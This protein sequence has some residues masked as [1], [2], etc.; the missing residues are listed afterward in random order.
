MNLIL[1]GVKLGLI[2]AI[3]VG[4]IF[5]AL[6]QAGVEEGAR[7]GSMVGFGIWASDILF[8]LCSYFGVSWI[9]KVVEGPR[10]TLY[11]GIGGSITLA[12]FGLATLLT[13]PRA[14][15]NPHWAKT[16]IRSTSYFSLWLKGFLINTI[17]PF[18]FFFWIGVTTTMVMDGGLDSGEASLFFGGILGTIITTDLAKVILAKRIRSFLQPIHLLWLRRISGAALIVFAVVLLVR[19]LWM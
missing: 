8:I 10:F 5:F 18:T 2:L 19:V 16:A 3:L 14:G 7:A 11:L 12:A 15:N 4:P 1:D 9:S 6:I 17:N 13:A